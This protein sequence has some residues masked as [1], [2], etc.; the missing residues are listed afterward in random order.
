MTELDPPVAKA[1]QP[2]KAD[3]QAAVAAAAAM[4][5]DGPTRVADVV[6]LD[7]RRLVGVV[8]VLAAELIEAVRREPEDP[9]E[10]VRRWGLRV[11]EL[12]DEPDDVGREDAE[13][14]A[15][16]PKPAEAPA[17][18]DFPTDSASLGRSMRTVL[19]AAS[20]AR[21]NRGAECWTILRGENPALAAQT[22]TSLFAVV[23]NSLEPADAE[24]RVV[25]WYKAAR[26]LE[27][28]Q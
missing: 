13:Q 19:A 14:P 6:D 17:D 4:L 11:A 24:R 2:T 8:R 1:T 7:L 16:T 20:A 9:Q 15:E 23:L 25:A 12:A 5:G 22:A 21:A 10:F 26:D 18:G 28:K 3:H 27:A